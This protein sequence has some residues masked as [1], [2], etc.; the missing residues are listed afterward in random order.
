[1]KHGMKAA[2]WAEIATRGEISELEMAGGMAALTILEAGHGAFFVRLLLAMGVQLAAAVVIGLTHGF[3][4]GYL[5]A[6]VGE[7]CDESCPCPG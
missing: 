4:A 6:A 2:R 1:M 3:A 7:M 5:A